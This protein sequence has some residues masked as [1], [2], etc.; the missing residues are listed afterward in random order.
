MNTTMIAS[1]FARKSS[2]EGGPGD[3]PLEKKKKA[4][5][6]TRAGMCCDWEGADNCIR[7]RP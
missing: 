4:A 3:S 2:D 6:F 7:M 1:K 5:K